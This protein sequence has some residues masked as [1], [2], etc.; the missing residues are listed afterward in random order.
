M[1]SLNQFLWNNVTLERPVEPACPN[2]HD[3]FP[4]SWFCYLKTCEGNH[5]GP[6]IVCPQD[7]YPIC[8][9]DGGRCMGKFCPEN[10]SDVGELHR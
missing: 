10:H 3:C 6:V 8:P 2:D 5:C 4:Y 1:F 9:G 7:W